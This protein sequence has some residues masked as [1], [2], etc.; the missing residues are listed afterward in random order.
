MEKNL[1]AGDDDVDTRFVAAVAALGTGRDELAAKGEGMLAA[2][3]EEK[4]N[5]RSGRNHLALGRGYARL[6][7]LAD[8][9][10]PLQRA[11]QA[12]PGSVEIRVRLARC[13][14]AAG[15]EEGAR[16]LRREAWAEHK[17][18]PAF[19]RKR[20][21][22]WAWRANPTA[23]VRAIA[24]AAVP[25]ALLAVCA[26][27]RPSPS[28][29]M[30]HSSELSYG[31]EHEARAVAQYDS[32]RLAENLRRIEAW[33]QEHDPAGAAALR[34]GLTDAQIDALTQ[35]AGVVLPEEVR[36]L[37]RWHDGT[38]GLFVGAYDFLSLENS[39]DGV[40][41]PLPGDWHVLFDL[42][43]EYLFIVYS[44]E[45]TTASAIWHYF[46]EEGAVYV[47][48][49][50]LTLFTAVYA[51]GLESGAERPMGRDGVDIDDARIEAIRRRLDPEARP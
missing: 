45:P 15:D 41:V 27:A 39:L 6:G 28:F 7:R 47:A 37:Y 3:E 18:A 20:E 12:R 22:L 24:L 43:G 14:D 36:A 48:H 13:L 5:H 10:A 31:G 32:D 35:K 9:R 29:L 17:S 38:E 11:L 8:A 19:E 49:T 40:G 50:N 16:K 1:A 21:R 51:E 2:L 33:K 4:P 30:G 26:V 23:G 34:P 46:P 42:E 25:L 44:D